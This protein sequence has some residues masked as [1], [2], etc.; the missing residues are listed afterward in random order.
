MMASSAIAL[1]CIFYTEFIHL[2]IQLHFTHLCLF[3]SKDQ[4]DE[5]YNVN[6]ASEWMNIM[7]KY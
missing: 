4:M 2:C 1:T 5:H 3:K 6:D 7:D